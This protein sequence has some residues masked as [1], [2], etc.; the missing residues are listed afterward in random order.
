MTGLSRCGKRYPDAA[1]ASMAAQARNYKSGAGWVIDS[2]R[3][4]DHWHVVLAANA[5]GK[6][7]RSDP[8]PPAV[9]KLLDARDE[10][11]QRCGAT[12]VRLE[13]HHRRAKASGGSGARAHTQCPCNGTKVCRSCHRH[14][15]EHPAESRQLG[16]IVSQSVALPGRCSVVRKV[17]E[18][19]TRP[20]YPTC[21][22]RWSIDPDQG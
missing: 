19:L 4:G 14:I 13:R 17:S 22:G 3:F 11:C 10:H 8:F 21:D 6:R 9:A 15:H 12:G 16:W 20:E 7:Y 2:C 5:N 1:W 18:W